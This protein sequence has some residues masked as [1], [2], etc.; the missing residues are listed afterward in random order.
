V[1]TLSVSN[2]GAGSKQPGHTF[3]ALAGI[4]SF[5]GIQ[6][7]GSNSNKSLM[8]IDLKIGSAVLLPGET[9]VSVDVTAV[10]ETREIVFHLTSAGVTHY[11][12]PTVVLEEPLMPGESTN[13]QF[14]FLPAPQQVTFTAYRHA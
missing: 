4:L 12:G 8:S 2:F 7:N 5:E 3:G 11:G 9:T 6:S 14:S 13:I 1:N 10:E